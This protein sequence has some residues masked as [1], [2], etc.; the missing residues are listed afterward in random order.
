[1]QEKLQVRTSSIFCFERFAALPIVYIPLVKNN[2]KCGS[3]LVEQPKK[4]KN[5]VK[6][7]FLFFFQ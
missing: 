1:M 3:N 4:Q 2:A 7:R 5:V 6:N